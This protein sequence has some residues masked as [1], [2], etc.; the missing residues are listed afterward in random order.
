MEKNNLDS[1]V[2]IKWLRYQ[3]NIIMLAF[4]QL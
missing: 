3:D 2:M 4:G 1:G